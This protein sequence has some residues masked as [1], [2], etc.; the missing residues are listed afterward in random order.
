VRRCSFFEKK[1]PK[2]LLLRFAPV[3]HLNRPARP[4]DGAALAAQSESGRA[5]LRGFLDFF[6]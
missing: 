3:F 2:K 4:D 6:A 5:N 1:A